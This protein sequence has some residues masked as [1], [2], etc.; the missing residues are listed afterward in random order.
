MSVL[1]SAGIIGR[2]VVNVSNAEML[3]LFCT[4]TDQIKTHS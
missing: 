2:F 1:L 3:D 4:A